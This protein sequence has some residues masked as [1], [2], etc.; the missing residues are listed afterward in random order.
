MINMRGR[1]TAKYRS[2]ELGKKILVILLSVSLLQIGII[3]MISYHLSSAIIT[4]QT[5]ELISESLEQSAGNIRAT[6]ER[7]NSVIQEIYTNPDYIDDL[8]IINSWDGEDYYRSKHSLEDKLRD[9]IY[10]NEEIMGIAIVG[11]YGDECFY[12]S[13]TLSSRKPYC[14]PPNLKNDP[15]VKDAMKQK[16]SIY[17]PLTSKNDEEYGSHSYFFIAHPLADFNNYKRGAEGCVILCIDESRFRRVYSQG[18]EESNISFL[19]DCYGNMVSFPQQGYHDTNLFPGRYGVMIGEEDMDVLKKASYDFISKIHY[20]RAG[21][22]S[23]NALSILNGEFFIVNIQ[24]LNYSLSK[25]RYLLIMICLV[26]GL[27]GA[28]CFLIVYYISQDTD[29]SVKKI[30]K[31]MNEANRGNLDSKAVVEGNDEFA[32][33]SEHFND[34]LAEIKKA[35]QQERESMVR[36]KNAEIRSLEAQINPHFLYNT[37]DTINW[38]AIEQQQFSISQMITKLAQ[39]LRYSI[40]NSNEIVTIR[41]ELEFL[42]KY[43]YLQQQRFDYSFQCSIDADEKVEE[44]CIHKL[45]LQP[46]VENTIIH[47][48]PDSGRPGEIDISIQYTEEGNISIEIKDNG[49]GMSPDLVRQLNSYDGRADTLGKSIG[50]RNVIT[51]IKLYY[52]D[53]GDIRFDSDLTGTTVRIAIP[54]VH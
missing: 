27:V 17:S 4:E 37:L 25:L 36:E 18:G 20:F 15:L 52:G 46:L 16:G 9:I 29:R 41:T 28:V 40:H 34:M 24:D 32:R 22:L 43:I 38:Q 7:F 42:K 21:N 33:I 19:V 1:L 31:A 45:L 51:R 14:F 44:C 50:V 5:Q 35:N 30:L 47:G 49:V 53:K 12:D 11:K 26:A 8:K 10:M 13:V 3:L 39:I 54:E 48:F 2:M 6:F 23:V